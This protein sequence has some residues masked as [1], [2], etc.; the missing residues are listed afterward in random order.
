M[1]KSAEEA[2]F[3]GELGGVYK[4]TKELVNANTK[5]DPP[6]L[7]GNK[8]QDNWPSQQFGGELALLMSNVPVGIKEASKKKKPISMLFC[9]FT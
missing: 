2:A 8:T 9:F 7:D 4:I 6:V 5:A 1:A 3:V